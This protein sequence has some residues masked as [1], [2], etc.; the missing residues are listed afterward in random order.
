MVIKLKICSI[1]YK[2]HKCKLPLNSY[3]LYNDTVSGRGASLGIIPLFFVYSC[4]DMPD[5]R[6]TAETCCVRLRKKRM[7]LQ[8][9]VG[10]R[11]FIFIDH[12]IRFI[13]L[14]RGQEIS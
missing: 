12:L 2:N 13:C 8:Y 10:V 6:L 1:T 11:L 7:V 5:V 4:D 9:S 14:E 3:T